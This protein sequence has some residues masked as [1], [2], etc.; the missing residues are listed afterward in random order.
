MNT[1]CEILGIERIKTTLYHPQSNDTIERM[2]GTLEA[3]L[4]KAHAKGMDWPRKIPFAL[5]ALRQ[6]HIKIWDPQEVLMS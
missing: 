2:H 1:L 4:T 5:F 6:A 3:M